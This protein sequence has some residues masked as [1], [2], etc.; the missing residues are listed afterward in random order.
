MN[1][2]EE[3]RLWVFLGFLAYIYDSNCLFP[4]FFSPPLTVAVHW[5]ATLNVGSGGAHASYYHKANEQVRQLSS[6]P[7]RVSQSESSAPLSVPRLLAYYSSHPQSGLRFHTRV[8]A[9][10]YPARTPVGFT[11]TDPPLVLVPA[12]QVQVGV[13]FEANT[14]LQDTTFSFGYHL[15]LPQ[16]D[17][18]FRGEG[19]E[20][21]RSGEGLGVVQGGRLHLTSVDSILQVWLINWANILFPGRLGG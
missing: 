7:S 12:S 2:G 10:L 15:T 4:L 20:T 17:M 3:G 8:P 16:A 9:C 14:R 13:E 18:V 19:F 5:V 21:L 6:S 1:G 11:V